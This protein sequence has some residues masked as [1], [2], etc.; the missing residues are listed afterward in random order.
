VRLKIEKLVYGGD[1]LARLPASDRG[2]GKSVFIP[3][4]VDG[5]TVAIQITE[6]KPGFA[7]GQLRQVIEPS[8]ERVAPPCPYFVR[9]GGC[10][11]QHM[12]Y[13][14]QLRTKSEILIETLRRTAK[15][16]LPCE[17]QLHRSPPWS[18]RN[19]ARLKL[20][21]EPEFGLGYYKFRSHELLPIEQCP[22]SSPLINRTIARLWS[23]GGR[24]ELAAEIREIELFTDHADERL[25]ITA[26]CDSRTLARTAQGIAEQLM[27]AVPGA[28]GAS[29]LQERAGNPAA[30]PKQLSSAGER[31]L[32]YKTAMASYRVS[33][34]AFFQVNRFLT[35]EL[36][37]VVT[38]GVS[39]R[40]ALDLY[41][42]VGLFSSVLAR[43]FAQVIAIE[44][45][46]I[47]YADLRHNSPEKVKAVWDT[48]AQYLGK[49]SALRADFVVVDP[50]RGGLGEVVV[51]SLAKLATPR[52]T[53]VSCDPA[54]LARDLRLLVSL[55]YRIAAAHLLDV[56]PQTYHI[57]SVFH[58]TAE[59]PGHR[60]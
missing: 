25:L 20:Q 4:A 16:A 8:P 15:L 11:Y 53:Y 44:A 58:L 60:A 32:T 49:A 47:S 5:E 9:C 38:D 41:A 59:S 35:E 51:R 18:Y 19:R 52:I 27:Q 17:L 45:S 37:R 46:P 6:Q 55:G 21:A 24:G 2:P 30:E 22:I 50:P 57:E 42:G 28:L 26:H 7:R 36:V 31:A 14:R 12:S 39:G 33:A 10:H 23:A 54:T 1:S 13:A 3:F 56:F 40:I 34:G 29:I 43:S 48:T